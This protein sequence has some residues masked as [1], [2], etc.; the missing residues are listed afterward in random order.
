MGL[1]TDLRH[2]HQGGGVA[3]Q[4]DLLA[5]IGEHQLFQAHLAALAL[6]HPDDARQIEP[7]FSEHLARH[8][9]LALAP[10]DQHQVGQPRLASL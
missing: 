9:H 10:I 4:V 8:G 6:L 5:A 2:Q 3:S 1:V 7:Q